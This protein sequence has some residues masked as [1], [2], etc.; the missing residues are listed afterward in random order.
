VYVQEIPSGV[1]AISGVATSVT[2]FIGRTRRGPIDVPV[3]VRSFAEYS[4][5]FGGLWQHSTLSYAVRLF[6]DNGG[7]DAVVVRVFN[8]DIAAC[9][10]TLTLPTAT[11]ALIL[12]AASPGSWGSALRVTIDDVAGDPDDARL[13]RLTIDELSAGGTVVTSEQFDDVSPGP[14]DDSSVGLV[15][16]Q[17]AL[18]RVRHPGPPNE[19]PEA[20]AVTAVGTTDDDGVD[21]TAAQVLGDPAAGTGLSALDPV[22]VNMLCL[23]PPAPGL[24]VDT[25][26][27]AAAARYCAPRATMLIVDAPAAGVADG[28]D[29]S[30]AAAWVTAL[31]AAVG[32]GA[33]GNVAAYFPRL[34]VADPLGGAVLEDVAPSGAVAGIIARTDADRGVWKAPAGRTAAISG[35]LGLS[36]AVTEDQSRHLTTLGLNCIRRFP[37]G[38]LIWG[39]RTLA[40]ADPAGSDW[41]Y[42]PVR[43][44]ALYIEE[45]IRRGTSWVV[46]EPNGEPLWARVRLQ[47]DAFMHE[48]FRRGALQG[49]KA[50]EAYFVKCD[51]ETT[52]RSDIERGVLNFLVGFAPLKPAEFVIL[53]FQHRLQ[54]R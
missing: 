33:E 34:T 31:R 3:P 14:D 26:T 50:A 8:G 13:F 54:E 15:L 27:W 18:V 32:G 53:S 41:R 9:T 20:G 38:V 7:T 5:L 47:V 17:S 49:A 43:R 46:F 48:L 36:H 22:R 42:V 11:G 28:D 19:V 29:V 16:G 12:E 23:P 6:F 10:P 45:S 52:T 44:T 37:S 40:G 24:D 2:A 25:A 51:A 21:I 35:V 4:R 1:G 39:A 30:G